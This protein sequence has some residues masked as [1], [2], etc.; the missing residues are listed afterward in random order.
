MDIRSAVVPGAQLVLAAC[1]GI[2]AVLGILAGD[3]AVAGATVVDGPRFAW[4]VVLPMTGVAALGLFDWQTGRGPAIL[5]AGNVAAFILAGIEL[6]M[7]TPGFARWLAG[8]IALAA[9]IG[10]A[11]SLLVPPPR[12]PGF[13]R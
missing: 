2:M 13:R 12:R 7:G 9:A 1:I 10:L 11:G 6:A 5:R 3:P 8:T 4:L